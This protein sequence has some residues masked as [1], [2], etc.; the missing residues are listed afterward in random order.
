MCMGMFKER[1]KAVMDY[2]QRTGA[3][4][5]PSANSVCD[6]IDRLIKKYAFS[7]N[8]YFFYVKIRSGNQKVRVLTRLQGAAAF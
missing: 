1:R 8:P 5:M 6:V 7:G 2:A 3:A 4:A